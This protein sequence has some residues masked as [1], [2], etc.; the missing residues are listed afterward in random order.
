MMRGALNRRPFLN[1]RF[2]SPLSPRRQRRAARIQVIAF[3]R[4][5]AVEYDV[6]II[7]GGP[8]GCACALYT[9]RAQHKTVILDTSPSIGA[10]AITS[11]IANYPGVDP[12]ISGQALLD[13]MRENAMSY[14]TDY[15]R[16]QVFAVELDGKYKTVY[17]PEQIFVAKTVVL[18]TGAMGRKASFKGEKELLGKGVSYC[19]TCDGAFYKGE[20]VVVV[21]WETEAIEEAT[22][23]L[24]FASKV[25]WITQNEPN[26]ENDLA[27]QLLADSKVQ[28]WSKTS[29]LSIE[30]SD[31]E[32]VTHVK[33]RRKGKHDI[34][35]EELK[36]R[37]VWIYT[38]GSQPITDFLDGVDVELKDDGGV[39]VDYDTMCTSIP[40]VYAIGDI[41][42][43]PYK[44]VVVA[45]ANGCIAAMSIDKYLKGRKNVRVDWLHK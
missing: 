10:L 11:T 5:K 39:Q 7:G 33:L 32:G 17:T 23:L 26:V 22:F 8:A 4:G 20:E 15:C 27:Q 18:A 6:A 29:L 40:G 34:E 30:G 19:A 12:T 16:A 41:R 31:A 3:E 45:A 38:A 13:N 44:Q 24:K 36:T 28:H 9:S 21:G 14:G 37:G 2:L 42:N 43:T 35:D 1:G 25:H